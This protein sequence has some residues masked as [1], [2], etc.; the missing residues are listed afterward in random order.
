MEIFRDN[1][2]TIFGAET[3]DLIAKRATVEATAIRNQ[4][5]FADNAKEAARAMEDVKDG[6]RSLTE[7]LESGDLTRNSRNQAQLALATLDVEKQAADESFSSFSLATSAIP[8]VGLFGSSA[9][10]Q[11]EDIGKAKIQAEEK[12][13]Q[14]LNKVIDEKLNNLFET[15]ITTLLENRLPEILD[16][17]FKNKK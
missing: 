3:T 9:E 11:Q 17:Y 15:K 4:K 16:N 1:V 12:K 6:S 2:L 10:T 14:A 7:A 5:Q 13:R 8:V